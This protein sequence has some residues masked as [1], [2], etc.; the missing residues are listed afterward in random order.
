M[1]THHES[2]TQKSQAVSRLG[3]YLPPALLLGGALAWSG[4]WFYSAHLT[5]QEIAAHKMAEAAKGRSWGCADQRIGGFPFR[6]E[7]HCASVTLDA[8]P[9]GQAM[10]VTS[11][12]LHA[13]TQIYS[14]TLVLADVDGPLTIQSADSKTSVAWSNLRVSARFNGR[15]DRLSLVMAKPELEVETL[16]GEKTRSVAGAAEAHFRY[17]PARPADDG[18]VDLAVELKQV[19]SAPVNAL[20]GTAEHMDL[21]ITG[22]ALKLAGLAP[23]GWRDLL[24]TWRSAGGSFV[25]ETGKLAKGA[26]QI[27]AKGVLGI[28]A[29]RRLQGK[30]DVSAAGL[31]PLITRFGGGGMNQMIAPLLARKDGSPTQW[32]VQLQEGRVQIGP[33]RTGPILGAL[34]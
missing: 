12:P 33:L 2:Q 11:G 18:A 24:E 21:S 15:L 13:A 34:Y 32:P 8:S 4:F 5:E 6:I 16:G 25:V 20:I 27:E 23:H 14:P 7:L 17:D 29:S 22:V 26:L 9:D 3:L 30:L 31:G 19:S 28:D 10:R 1:T